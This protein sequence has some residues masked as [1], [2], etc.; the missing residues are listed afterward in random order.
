ML[1]LQQNESAV[2]RCVDLFNKRTL[3]WVDTCFAE[4]VK[5]IELAIPGISRGR[6]G[7]R[8]F[9]RETA[10][11]IL[12]LYPDRQMSIRNLI[13][14]GDQVVLE[15]DWWGTAAAAVGGLSVGVQVR[16]RVASFFTLEDGLI[17]KQTDYCV[18]I[19]ND[20]CPLCCSGEL[21]RAV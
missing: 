10:E 1:T 11:S 15:L 8:A 12:R 18:P 5:W 16:F 9:L 6:Q 2:R 19:P 14:Q 17:V 7:N 13:A 21:H 4:N 3:A 20:V